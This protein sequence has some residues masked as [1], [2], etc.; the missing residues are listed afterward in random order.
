M[1]MTH[2][3]MSDHPF[4]ENPSV[5][6]ILN[7]DRFDQ[8]IARL[9]YFQEQGHI[10]L[11][12]GQTGVGKSSLIRV[13]KQSIPKNRYRILYL[14]MTNISPT[15]F[16]RLIVTQL[17]ESPKLGKDRLFLQI[18]ERIQ[19]NETETV[20]IIDEA[21]LVPSQALTDIRLLVSTGI[22]T[23][24]PLK[25]ILCGQES[26]SYLLNRSAHADLV[27]RISVRCS[28]NSL[29]RS[30][31]TTYIDHRLRCVDVSE[32]IFDQEAKNIIHDY[33]GGIPRQINNIATSSLINAA[34]RNHQKIDEQIVN[35]TMIEFRLP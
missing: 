29:T 6:W 12:I 11:I 22:D 3:K 10:A 19:K 35:E 13:F 7:D 16:L 27:H 8:A 21:H 4:S 17:G 18:V 34:S 1:F 20:L 25:V 32:K 33:S 28:L 5:D 9:N 14:H 23:P 30:Q 15:A 31:T 26:I 24:L 2:F